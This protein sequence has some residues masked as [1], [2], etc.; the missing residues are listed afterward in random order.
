M[1]LV[2]LRKYK[3][4]VSTRLGRVPLAVQGVLLV[5]I[6]ALTGSRAKGQFGPFGSQRNAPATTTAQA[7]LDRAPL[8]AGGAA[9][10]AIRVTVAP[11]YHI[12]SA[13]PHD[14]NLLATRLR[15]PEIPGLTFGAVQYP[16]HQEIHAPQLTTAGTLAAY[17]GTIFLL[18]PVQ[19]AVDAS[20][21]P[22]T[23]RFKLDIQAC[24]DRQCQLP[25][26]IETPLELTVAS[27]GTASA[28]QQE[29]LFAKA[30]AQSFLAAASQPAAS[31]LMTA[32]AARPAVASDEPG[33]DV[34]LMSDDEQLQLLAKAGYRPA[35]GV[36]QSYSLGWILLFALAGG[37]ILNVMPCVLPVIPLKVLGLVQQAHGNRRQ[38]FVHGVIFSA[39]VVTLFILLALVLR[40]AGWFYGQQFQSVGFLIGMAMF[41]LALALSMLGVFTINPPRAIYTLDQPHGGATAS[42]M[43]GLL[44]TLL[45]T[46]CSAPYLGPVLAWALIQPTWLTVLALAVVGIGMSLPYLLLTAFP[47]GLSWVP[48]AGRWTELFKQAMGIVMIGVSIYLITRITT[49]AYWP[50]VFFGA[51]VLTLVCW[52]WGQIPTAAMSLGRTW[53]VRVTAVVIGIGLGIGLYRLAQASVAAAPAT[54]SVEHVVRLPDDLRG[55]WLDFNMALVEAGLKQGRPVIIDWTANWCINC[56]VVEATVLEAEAVQTVFR[57]RRAVLL[58]ADLSGANPPAQAL[59]NQLESQAIPVL[60]ILSP[61]QP[62]E[63]VVLRDIYSQERVIREVS[64]AQERIAKAQE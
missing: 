49:I 64:A 59:L 10:V 25:A 46:P 4:G 37:A 48:R 30:R 47:A 57:Q 58:R 28:A 1:L 19:A 3:R 9:T 40:T 12:Q 45:A 11:G 53:T 8:P 14:P 50:W 31:P 33:V 26:Q 18:V 17:E 13:Q 24:D 34:R 36:Q 54:A 27:A 39:G 61:S 22:R 62:Y 44:A 2:T 20:P 43:N 29:E 16:Q 6:L 5:M 55:R 35:T 63:P 21:G 15:V 41:I 42:F 32:E 7:Y 56:R 38:A 51:L 60:A 52:A 23:I